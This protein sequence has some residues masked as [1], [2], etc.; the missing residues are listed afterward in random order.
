M[1]YN[2]DSSNSNAILLYRYG[3]GST[4]YTMWDNSGY[5]SGSDMLNQFC[6]VAMVYQHNLKKLK[7]YI[8]GVLTSDR[9]FT[10]PRTTFNKGFIGKSNFPNE[11]DATVGT[12]DEFRVTDGAALW[13]SNFT[14]P[15]TQSYTQ[16]QSNI[17]QQPQTN[18]NSGFTSALPFNE[19]VNYDENGNEWKVIGN[20]ILSSNQYI[21]GGKS[22]Y[23]DGNSCLKATTAA[24]FDFPEEFTMEAWIYPVEWVTDAYGNSFSIFS[25]WL[26]GVRTL[27]MVNIDN[28]HL[29][30]Y[31]DFVGSVKVV[32]NSTVPLNRWTH[33][34]VTR[35]SG[36]ILRLFINGNLE[37]SR[38][39][40]LDFTDTDY[41]MTLGASSN[42]MRKSKGYI[43]EWHVYK[44]CLYTNNFKVW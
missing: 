31:S 26:H 43:D 34:A 28:G 29:S 38:M 17:P 40:P 19:Y 41:P 7:T 22:L 3:S 5:N 12:I 35:D 37:A 23:L 14:P 10:I 32:S 2:N 33:V 8:N 42:E 6:H 36:N 44:K 13:T 4:I 15:A 11:G 24:P 20:P 30:F 18:S 27:Y 16:P 39:I 21:S 9:D 1:F 25:R